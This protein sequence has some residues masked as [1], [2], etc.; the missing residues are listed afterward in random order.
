MHIPLYIFF[1]LNK[2][3]NKNLQYS[4]PFDICSK[5]IDR[6]QLTAYESPKAEI[7][8]KIAYEIFP[9]LRHITRSQSE[10]IWQDGYDGLTQLL[11][12]V[13]LSGRLNTDNNSLGVYV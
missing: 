1:E 9:N 13:V 5:D 7:F 6:I 2:L 10:P 3:L 12:L 8:G 11:A 4:N